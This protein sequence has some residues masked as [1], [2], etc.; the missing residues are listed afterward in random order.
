[1][2]QLAPFYTPLEKRIRRH[3]IGPVHTFTIV[4]SPGLETVCARELAKGDM[5]AQEITVFPGQVRFKG[6]IDALFLTN[7]HLRTASRILMHLTEFE[8]T[9]FSRLEKK[10]AAF[11]WEL[12]IH[13]TSPLRIRASVRQC[14]LRHTGAVAERVQKA[15]TGRLSQS[16]EKIPREISSSV[17]FPIGEGGALQRV[18]VHGQGDRF[19]LSLD[20]SGELL[21][22]RGIKTHGGR[23]PLRETLAAGILM[24]AGYTPDRPLLD[25]MCGSGT[26]CL[27]AAL[28]ARRMPPGLL[29]SFAFM[30]WPA[31]RAAHWAHMRR[32]AVEK[33]RPPERADIFASDIDPA[34]CRNLSVCIASH[35]LSGVIQVTTA[36]FFSL[37]GTAYGNGPGLVVLNPPYGHRLESPGRSQK[38]FSDIFEKLKADFIGWRYAVVSPYRLSLPM[39]ARRL[40][41]GGLPIY[42]HMGKIR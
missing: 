34:A 23:A 6:R 41:H 26:F 30:E 2:P 27:E 8:A 4:V 16:G 3:V 40:F 37:T 39:N 28:M 15:I 13:R 17:S 25:P 10:T 18:F 9:G 33:I 24:L 11:P 32:A 35:D 19:T 36:G 29:R 7:L 22:K 38:L 21:Y 31:F 1:M 14:R 5:E 12:F 20:S 42:L